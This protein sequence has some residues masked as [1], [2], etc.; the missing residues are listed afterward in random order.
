MHHIRTNCLCE[1]IRAHQKKN[2]KKTAENNKQTNKKERPRITTYTPPGNYATP[3]FKTFFLWEQKG[4]VVTHF[5]AALRVTQ[6]A[7]DFI[8]L[9][10]EERGRREGRR[11]EKGERGGQ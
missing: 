2:N 9:G 5:Q 4:A 8:N 11:R 10:R 7:I 3:T 1:L 6:P